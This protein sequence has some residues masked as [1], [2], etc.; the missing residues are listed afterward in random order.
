[1]YLRGTGTHPTP[2]AYSQPNSRTAQAWSNSDSPQT[3]LPHTTQVG[4]TPRV[5]N[6]NEHTDSLYFIF[7]H[8]G[9]EERKSI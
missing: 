7:I 6:T 1:M 3:K 4:R 2:E 8:E 5:C 9:L